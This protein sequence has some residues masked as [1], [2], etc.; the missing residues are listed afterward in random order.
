MSPMV[1]EKYAQIIRWM[2]GWMNGW[3]D[4]QIKI[5]MDGQTDDK[6]TETEETQR[7][8]DEVNGPK[9]KKSSK[10]RQT[11]YG[12]GVFL[13]PFLQLFCKSKLY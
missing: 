3:M 5:E 10:S 8:N 9:C 1:Q 7:E 13:I 11:V 2:D 6:E 4:E 12:W